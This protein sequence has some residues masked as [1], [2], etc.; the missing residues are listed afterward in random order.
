M[1]ENCASY[2]HEHLFLWISMWISGH[3]GGK[4]LKKALLKGKNA[5]FENSIFIPKMCKLARSFSAKI[6]IKN[7]LI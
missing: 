5:F 3:F 2:P 7:T 1:V 6:H 4:F